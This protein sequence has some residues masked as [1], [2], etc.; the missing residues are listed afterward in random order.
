MLDKRRTETL[1]RLSQRLG[2]SFS[3]LELLHQALIHTSY[4][5]EAKKCRFDDNER[6][7]FLGDAVLDAIVSDYLFR[8]FPQMPEGELTKARASIVCEPSLAN[9]SCLVGL[10]ELLMLGR[11]EEASGGRERVSILA[12]AFEAVIGAIYLDVGFQGAAEFVLRQFADVFD[13]IGAGHYNNDFKTLLQE[14]V[15]RSGDSKIH[16]QV[17]SAQGPDHDK[18][19]KVAVVV[20]GSPMGQGSGKT[21]KEAEQNAARQALDSLP[22]RL[23]H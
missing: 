12:D 11:G 19:F 15:Q 5:N 16:Y 23:L 8:R 2:V 9:Q 17:V 21:K 6:L 3:R 20:N 22:N 4:V 18:L 7:E 14:T 1:D 13:Q 10:G